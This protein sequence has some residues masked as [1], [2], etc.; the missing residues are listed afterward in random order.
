[1]QPANMDQAMKMAQMLASSAMVP[2]QYQNKT[3]DTLVAMMMG[4]EL[5]LNPIQ[6]L[7]NI[8]VINGR[9][10][11][12]GDALIALVQNHPA[13]GGI[14]ETF[15]EST[16]TATCTAWRKGGTKHTQTFSKA[17]AQKAGLWDER[18]KVRRK[19]YS[20][21]EFYE[22]NNDAPWF[23]YP[24]R[25]LQMRARG[26]TL[27]DTFADALAGLITVEEAR[28][29]PAEELDV[30]PRQEQ[31]KQL[32]YYPEDNFEQNFDTWKGAIESGKTT[33][34]RVIATV[35]TKAP[36]TDKQKEKIRECEITDSEE[37][38]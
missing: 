18:P 4:S 21:G 17:D 6:S 37:Q 3:E 34:D 14:E 27:R 25:M 7:Q 36:L 20:T 22:A 11:I 28:D 9:P 32:A 38:E 2:K 1:M 12:Y 24:K 33:A 26:F 15:D 35:E 31:P 23:R 19:N 30:T 8:A 29:I 13:F 16:M 5:G 10:S